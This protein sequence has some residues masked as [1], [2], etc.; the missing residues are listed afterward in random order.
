M[1]HLYLIPNAGIVSSDGKGFQQLLAQIHNKPEYRPKCLCRGEPGID[2]NVAHLGDLY[3]VKRWPNSGIEHAVDC[4]SYEPPAEESG[5]GDVL[6]SAIKWNDQDGTTVLRF[7]FSLSKGA[8][9]GAGAGG[10]SSRGESTSVHAETKRLTLK[11]TLDYLYDEAELN[12]WRPGM[13]GKRNW[14]VIRKYLLIAADGKLSKG[15]PLTDALYVP[16]AIYPEQQEEILRRRIARFAKLAVPGS[17]PRQLMLFIAEAKQV[18]AGPFG[19]KLILKQ[20][21]DYPFVMDPKMSA[22]FA[23]TFRNEL[24]LFKAIDGSHLLSIGIFGVAPSGV[25]SLED[26]S[27]MVVNENWIP[28]ANLYEKELVDKLTKQKRSFDKGLRYNR[29]SKEVMASVVLRDVATP[30]AMYVIPQFLADDKSYNEQLEAKITASSLGVWKWIPGQEDLPAI[31]APA[32]P[33]TR[34]TAVETVSKAAPATSPRPTPV[35]ASRA[36]SESASSWDTKKEPRVEPPASME[37][38][39]ESPVQSEVATSLSPKPAPEAM[40]AACS[41]ASESA[42]GLLNVVTQDERPPVTN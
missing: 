13:A 27:V 36:V 10:G 6:G 31:P 18:V 3:F 39:K 5:R 25:A 17:G 33:R 8:L 14:R 12:S 11:G 26:L 32:P 24:D 7:D 1:A 40:A 42:P 9:R 35:A 21:D 19:D 15:K 29:S 23:K 37:P 30:V 20:L 38:A 28:I 16:E 41:V 22:A 34:A 4:E 2:M